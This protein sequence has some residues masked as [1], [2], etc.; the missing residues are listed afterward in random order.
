MTLEEI[1]ASYEAVAEHLT[2]LTQTGESIMFH[3]GGPEMPMTISGYSY[4]I[5]HSSSHSNWQ[6]E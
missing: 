4:S 1:K 3:H 2:K 5:E 6:V